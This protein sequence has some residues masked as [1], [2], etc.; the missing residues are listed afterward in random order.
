M[1]ASLEGESKGKNEA[2]KQKKKI[3]GEINDLEVTLDQVNRNLTDLQKSNKK[4][5]QTINELESRIEDEQR[6]RNDARE[7]VTISERK[8]NMLNG[9]LDELR[10][11]LEQAEKARKVAENDLRETADRISYLESSNSNLNNLKRKLDS[12]LTK[13]QTNMDEAIHELK[14]SEERVKSALNDA[15]RLAEELKTEQVFKKN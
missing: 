14:N 10:L 4:L 13:C 9:E 15:S 1:E 2:L 3:E 6:Q 5:Q 7:A 11:T 12:E 8:S